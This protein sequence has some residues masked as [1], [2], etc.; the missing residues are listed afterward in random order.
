MEIYF[1]GPP[2]F[3]PHH[4][5][6]TLSVLLVSATLQIASIGNLIN[7][8]IYCFPM[9]VF[10]V[11]L[12]P[13]VPLA[14]P[15]ALISAMQS[16]ML[17]LDIPYRDMHDDNPIFMI[18]ATAFAWWTTILSSVVLMSFRIWAATPRYTLGNDIS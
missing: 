14:Q 3:V 7:F 8:P 15:Q 4:L 5:Q 6:N 17:F 1:S 18:Q 9:I 11:F 12:G 2:P 10:M 13:P 16:P